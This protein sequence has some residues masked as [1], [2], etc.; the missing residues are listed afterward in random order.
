MRSKSR[1]TFLVSICLV[2]GSMASCGSNVVQGLTWE[3]AKASSQKMELAI[4]SVIPTSDVVGVAQ[5]PQGTLLS[6][7][8]GGHL[9]AGR[10]EVK[11]T[12]G[13]DIDTILR[14]IQKHYSNFQFKELADKDIKGQ[15]RLQLV[16]ADG[17]ANYLISH[18]EPDTVEIDSGSKCFVLPEGTYPGGDF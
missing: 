9:W 11:L 13:T 2:T 6:C 5:Q 12:P 15:L 3:E 18:G 4:A 7:D 1:V 16:A 10:T 8:K 17:V 14:E